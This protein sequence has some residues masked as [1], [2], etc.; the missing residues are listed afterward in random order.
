MGT[1]LDPL[2]LCVPNL[3]AQMRNCPQRPAESL[4]GK[5]GQGGHSLDAGNGNSGY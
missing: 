5:T 1:T 4:V 3:G 2:S